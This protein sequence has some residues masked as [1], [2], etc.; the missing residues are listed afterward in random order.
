MQSVGLIIDK[1]NSKKLINLPSDNQIV[2]DYNFRYVVTIT[3]DSKVF[4]IY[5]HG[6]LH[7]K[8]WYKLIKNLTFIR[9]LS[10]DD[11]PS[12]VKQ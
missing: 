1:N 3:V 10:V 5:G 11:K 12:N 8:F 2:A 4:M 9:Y 6:K 7:D